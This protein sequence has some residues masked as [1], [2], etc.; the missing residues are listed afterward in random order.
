MDT[1]RNLKTLILDYER[2]LIEDCEDDDSDDHS[3]EV[4]APSTEP[5]VSAAVELVMETPNPDD[6][7]ASTSKPKEVK[8]DG[9]MPEVKLVGS[10]RGFSQ[11][12]EAKEPSAA[13]RIV[14]D[15]DHLCFLH[16]EMM[17]KYE[18]FVEA[19]EAWDAKA[20]EFK[21]FRAPKIRFFD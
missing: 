9:I 3:P 8:D 17:E 21:G 6:E 15:L 4:K 19:H 5:K 10:K 12:S 14:A 1:V 2:S 20:S 18:R 16:D 7:L 11:M 13:E